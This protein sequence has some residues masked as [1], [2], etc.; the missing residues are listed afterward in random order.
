MSHF[1]FHKTLDFFKSENLKNKKIA[2]GVS[3]GLDS[4]VLLDVLHQLTSPKKLELFVIH[5]HHGESSDDSLQVYRK[6][7]RKLVAETCKFLS[8]PFRESVPPQKE[9][10]SE[11]D[12]RQFRYEQFKRF[13]RRKRFIF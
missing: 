11:E 4:M 9:L 5:V 7:S 13:S 6:E 10:K 2:V 3:G 1:L 12:F 8:I